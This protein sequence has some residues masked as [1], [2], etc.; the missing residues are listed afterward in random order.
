[1]ER[2]CEIQKPYYYKIGVFAQLSKVTIKALHHYDEKGLLKP[3]YVDETNGYRYYTSA[4]LPILQRILALRNIGFS[5]EEIKQVLEGNKEASLLIKKKA[6]LH[7]QIGDLMKQIACIESYLAHQ[8]E[9]SDVHVMIK[10]LPEVQIVSMQVHLQGYAELF[11]KMPQMGMEMERSGCECAQPDYC[12]TLYDARCYQDTEI[13]ARICQAIT[14]IDQQSD[15][16]TVETLP[17]VAEAACIYHKGAYETF[18]Q[19]YQALISFIEENGYE[20]IDT[21][22]ECYID[23]IWNQ[24]DVADWLSEIQVPIRKREHN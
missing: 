7:N 15:Q 4:Q 12:F 11:T 2:H 16:L 1:M 17:A 14:K 8:R 13:D 24:E 21:P 6:D 18:P 20:I 22:R 3:A 19:S 23:G 5:L 9:G 10:S